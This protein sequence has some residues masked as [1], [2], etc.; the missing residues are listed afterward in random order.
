MSF[1]FKINGIEHE[2]TTKIMTILNFVQAGC[3]FFEFIGKSPPHTACIMIGNIKQQT[4][5]YL[6]SISDSTMKTYNPVLALFSII[7]ILQVLFGVFIGVA[8]MEKLPFLN[9]KKRF[10][11]G[12]IHYGLLVQFGFVCFICLEASTESTIFAALN[13]TKISQFSSQD[14]SSPGYKYN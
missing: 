9:L 10:W 11:L 5:D 8:L 4:N 13:D 6:G 14:S 7:G 3:G 12:V 2:K 1:L